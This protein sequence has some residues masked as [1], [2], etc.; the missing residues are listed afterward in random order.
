MTKDVLVSI[1]GMQF[2][3][4]EDEP[5]EPIEIITNGNYYFRNGSHYVKYEEVFEGFEETTSNLV[6]IKPDCIELRKK[7]AANVHM[8]FEE[9][10][11]NITYYGTPFGNIQM[12]ISTTG[13]H[14][15]EEE[16]KMHVRIEYT[17]DMNDAYVADCTLDMNVQSK[18]KKD[19][20]S[21]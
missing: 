4:I 12:G 19:L 3:G 11:K 16:E 14:I 15:Q 18:I 10:K 20:H 13:I 9:N 2:M 8:V 7:G 5:D 6:K 17:L 1:K 21:R